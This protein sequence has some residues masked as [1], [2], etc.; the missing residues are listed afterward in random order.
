MKN[1]ESIPGE[2]RCCILLSDIHKSG[3]QYKTAA[4]LALSEAVD[5]WGQSYVPEEPVRVNITANYARSDIAVRVELSCGFR[6]PCSRCLEETRLAINGDM[7]Y[8]F[9]MRRL[10]RAEE[11]RAGGEEDGYIDA[12]EM[13][14]FQAELD[15]SP[16]IWET[17][18]LNLPE[19]VLCREECKGLCPICGCSKNARECGCMTDETDPRLGALKN[20]LW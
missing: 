1:I 18:I 2:L 17:L 4:E 16:Y 20:F 19:R 15:L 6:V 7:R 10:P 9:T 12:I 11:E 8:L 5:Y 14:K 3:E 13:E